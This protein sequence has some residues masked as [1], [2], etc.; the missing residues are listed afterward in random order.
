MRIRLRYLCFSFA[1]E[2]SRRAFLGPLNK[3]ISVISLDLSHNKSLITHVAHVHVCGLLMLT[4][5]CVYI[6]NA[7][8]TAGQV[9]VL[10]RSAE[11][12]DKKMQSDPQGYI[13]AIRT[14]EKPKPKTT[15]LAQRI[16][17]DVRKRPHL[18][19]VC[20]SNV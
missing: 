19:K 7:K 8:Y 11:L 18:S 14:R 16:K 4:A 10:K 15:L 3:E 17:R 6:F 9:R 20:K 12:Q 2:G 1:S 13:Y 5:V